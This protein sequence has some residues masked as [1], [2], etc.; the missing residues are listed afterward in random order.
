MKT[1]FLSASVPDPRR[2]PR[3]FETA[4]LLAIGDAVHAL[5]TVVLPRDRLVFG[6]HPAIIPI[7]QR[8]A[9]ILDRHMSVSLYLSAFFKNQFPAEYQHFNNLVLTEPGRDRAH[10]IDLMR[11]QMLASAR[12]DAG[13]FIGGMEG[14]IDEWR[15]FRNRRQQA[16]R[17]ADPHDRSGGA[18]PL[19][20]RGGSQTATTGSTKSCAPTE[21]MP[22]SSAVCSG[23]PSRSRPGR[24]SVTTIGDLPEQHLPPPRRRRR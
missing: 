6:G 9:A 18:H 24:K 10:S 13:V 16:P 20:E 22:C 5:C 23:S 3:F 12:F 21:F 19:R 15:L 2:D 4:D 17:L 11:E 8:V 14:V 7:V 1:V